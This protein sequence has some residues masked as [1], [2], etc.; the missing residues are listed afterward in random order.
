MRPRRLRMEAFGAYPGRQDLDFDI[1]GDRRFFLIHGATGSGKTTILDAICFALY[2]TL[3]GSARQAA[4]ARSEMADDDAETSV[5]LD[6]SLGSEH[7]R[8]ER[9][10][11]QVRA[12]KRGEGTTKVAPKATLWRRTNTTDDADEGKVMAT[13]PRNV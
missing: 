8:V 12:K 11:E 7:Y 10:P 1:L 3:S 2:G 4:N 5:R 13:G 6:F 9:K